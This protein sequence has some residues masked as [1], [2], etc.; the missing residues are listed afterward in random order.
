MAEGRR[1]NTAKL[2]GPLSAEKY[3]GTELH[4][5]EKHDEREH[6]KDEKFAHC[7]FSSARHHKPTAKL[8]QT[9]VPGADQLPAVTSTTACAN[10]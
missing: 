3:S 6:G 4:D 2:V 10:A 1:E 8:G 9:A 7:S 5:G